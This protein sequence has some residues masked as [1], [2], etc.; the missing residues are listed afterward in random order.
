VTA[1]REP[2][3]PFE[4]L[5]LSALAVQDYEAL[6]PHLQP[7]TSSLGKVVY[8]S[9]GRLDHVY[10]PTN[11]VVSLL[12]IMEDGSIAEMGLAGNDG[13]VGS[14]CSWEATQRPTGPSYKSSAVLSE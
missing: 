10:F 8:E 7:V 2:H 1:S 4:N 9:G 14:R 12:Y 5:L 11:C 13:V 6:L 3:S